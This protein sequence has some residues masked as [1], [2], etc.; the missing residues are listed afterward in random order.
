MDDKNP[1]LY[2][3]YGSNLDKDDWNKWCEAIKT[4][5]D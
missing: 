3:G 2:F 4:P 5:L 1:T